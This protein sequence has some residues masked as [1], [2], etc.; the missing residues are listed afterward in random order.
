MLAGIVVK[1][2]LSLQAQ[3][4]ES[5]FTPSDVHTNKLQR[6]PS[7]KI[8]ST[9]TFHLLSGQIDASGKLGRTAL[10]PFPFD[11]YAGSLPVYTFDRFSNEFLIADTFEDYEALQSNTMMMNA[12]PSPGE[13][14]TNTSESASFTPA[15]NYSSNDLWLE[16]IQMTNTTADLVIHPPSDA[17]NNVYDLYFRTNLNLNPTSTFSLQWSRIQRSTNGQTNLFVTNLLS[18]QGFFILGPLTNAIRPGFDQQFLARNDDNQF[19]TNLLAEIGFSIDF[20]SASYTNL[21]VNNNGNVTFDN[22]LN[23]FTPTNLIGLSIKIIAPFWADVDTRN[24]ESEVVRY[25]TNEVDGHSA[26]GVDWVNV[27][28]F[29]YSGGQADKLLS[30]Q[31]VIVDRSDIVPGDFDMEFNYDKAEWEWGEASIN[32]PPR[33]GYF[34]GGTNSY[35]LPGSGIQSAF[36]DSNFDTG[37]IFHSMNGPRTNLLSEPVSGRYRFFFRNGAPLH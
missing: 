15:Y 33:A 31:L 14:G 19:V 23:T 7:G 4:E 18:D 26:F 20:F 35:E 8:P 32:V 17:T 24:T 16:I 21:Y 9:G 11:P 3:T 5:Y 2:S 25:G 34:D 13:G 29:T 27:G 30:C 36:L 12:P 28:Y 37:L 6:V 1:L 22:A 10:P